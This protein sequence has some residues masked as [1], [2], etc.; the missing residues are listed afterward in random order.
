M[1]AVD[2]L[3]PFRG[4]QPYRAEDQSRFFCRDEVTRRLTNSILAHP[5]VSLFSPSGAGKSSLMQAAVLPQLREQHG[6]RTVCVDAWLAHEDPLHRVARSMFVDLDLGDM[7]DGRNPRELIDEAFQLAELRSSRPILLFLDQLEQT[8]LPSR[9]PEGVRALIDTLAAIL[10]EPMRDRQLVLSL[11]EDYLGRLRDQARASRELLDRGFRLG[12][13]TV[14]EMTRIV[15]RLAAMGVPAQE[16]CPVQMQQL[17]L[18]MRTPGQSDSAEAEVQ[19]AFA[20]IVCRALWEERRTCDGETGPVAAE[21]ILHRYLDTTLKALGPT[22]GYSARRLMEEYLVAEGGSRTLVTQQ[23]AYEVLSPDC[24]EQVLSQLQDAAVL[25]S[26]HHEGSRYF[27]LGHDWLANK[28]T[29]LKRGRRQ[30]ELQQWEAAQ[31]NRMLRITLAVSSLALLM[32]FLAFMAWMYKRDA[33]NQSLMTGAREAMQRGQ[34]AVAMKLLA[35][36]KHPKP[37]RQWDA[38]ALEAM[39]SN[40]LEVTLRGPEGQSVNAA[41]FSPDGRRIVTGSDDGVVRVW[42]ADGHEAPLELRGHTAPVTAAEFSRDGRLIVTA[43][44]DGTARVWATGERTPPLVFTHSDSV[45]FATF[46]PDN[47]RILTVARDGVARLWRI[48]L[49]EGPPEVLNRSSSER[50]NFAAFSPDGQRLVM[51]SWDR[52]V[53]VWRARGDSFEREGKPL[54][55]HGGPVVFAAFSQDGLRLVTTSHDGTA[56]LWRTEGPGQPFVRDRRLEEHDAPVTSAAFSPDRQYIATASLDGT[57]RVWQWDGSG[58]PFILRGHTAPINSVAFTQESLPQRLVTASQDGTARVWRAEASTQ[59]LV[60]RV[61]AHEEP[62]A[63]AA[64]SPDGRHVVTASQDGRARVW[65]AEGFREPTLLPEEHA[66]AL[67][68][69]AFS[70]DGRRFVTSSWDKTAVVW[71]FDSPGERPRVF[72]HTSPVT[73]A[74]LSSDGQRLVTG[75][76][77]RRAWVWSVEDGAAAS[78]VSLGE[79]GGPVTSVTFSPDDRF[80]VTTSRDATLRVWPA[81]GGDARAILKKHKGPVL[82][83]AFSPDGQRLVTASQ[84]GDVRLWDWGA[85]H[86]VPRGV[87]RHDGPVLSARFSPDGRFIV[88]ASWDGTA[89]VWLVGEDRVPRVLKGHE[90]PIRSAMF[91]GS[92]RIVTASWDGTARVWDLPEDLEKPASRAERR[93]DLLERNRDCLLPRMREDYLRESEA[94]ARKGYARCERDYR[95][96][97]DQTVALRNDNLAAGSPRRM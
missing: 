3:N 15:C 64:V 31:R 94:K 86:P 14:K 96:V 13:L 44:A 80:I 5:C 25:R 23:Q 9:Q 42:N 36:V 27:E 62:L 24:A 59:P 70:A 55:G 60:S 45:R 46:H 54:R 4:P 10:R 58:P 77:E 75:T 35:E 32:L 83:V 2:S 26:E 50:L 33:V 6:I 18:Q 12:P 51:T 49:P 92:G 8:L 1:S 39:D 95:R 66:Q 48:D 30:L 74:A 79:H 65:D 76:M 28:V 78:P 43:S 57:A 63:S 61:M 52:T 20:Q 97:P 41:S 40:F 88:T 17:M 69:V 91:A 89:R 11:R 84:D 72:T 93:D 29:E 47:A 19:A 56:W 37:A 82:S 7:P 87:L 90:G 21:P 34:P 67:T 22:Q 16:W 85:G 81:E 53:R 38:L 71:R 73:S 68:S